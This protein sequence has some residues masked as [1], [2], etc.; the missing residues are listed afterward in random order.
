MTQRSVLVTLKDGTQLE[1]RGKF[2]PNAPGNAQGLP[3]DPTDTILA[4]VH[5]AEVAGSVVDVRVVYPS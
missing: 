4:L 2:S 5:H 1:V 3:L